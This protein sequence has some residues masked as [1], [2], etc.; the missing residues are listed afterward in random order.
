MA[1][2]G[3]DNTGDTAESAC[4]FCCF[5][6]ME[7]S[8]NCLLGLSHN[9]CDNLSSLFLSD[10]SNCS[11]NNLDE[12]LA[13][14]L[15][16]LNML[17]SLLLNIFIAKYFTEL[18]IIIVSGCLLK[19]VLCSSHEYFFLDP[20]SFPHVLLFC[21]PDLFPSLCLRNLT[22]LMAPLLHFL[23]LKF[24]IPLVSFSTLHLEVGNVLSIHEE[25]ESAI[26]G[27][28]TGFNCLKN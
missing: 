4:A 6:M 28:Y 12:Y 23:G 21:P 7:L 19:L 3:V 27:S 22:A 2:V 13:P 1:L 8:Y 18:L 9:E 5:H 11:S 14:L 24:S 15:S 25:L 26:I 16:S 17:T 10:S 20:L